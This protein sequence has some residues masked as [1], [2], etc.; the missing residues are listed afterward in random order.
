MDLSELDDR[1]Q[2]AWKHNEQKLQL[3]VRQVKNYL[4]LIQDPRDVARLSIRQVVQRAAFL[5][6]FRYDWRY[7]RRELTDKK[8]TTRGWEYLLLDIMKRLVQSFSTDTK[9]GGAT[10]FF[11]GPTFET[12]KNFIRDNMVTRGSGSQLLRTYL[13]KDTADWRPFLLLLMFLH[14]REVLSAQGFRKTFQ[15]TIKPPPTAASVTAEAIAALEALSS[16]E[17]EEESEEEQPLASKRTAEGVSKKKGVKFTEEQKRSRRETR[18]RR[19]GM[20]PE[21]RKLDMQQQ[22]KE[23]QQQK[24]AATAELPDIEEGQ[25]PSSP[26]YPAQSPR[27]APV[28]IAPIV[29]SSESETEEELPQPIE[30]SEEEEEEEIVQIE[31]SEEEEEEESE[32]ESEEE[33]S[34]LPPEY[35]PGSAVNATTWESRS[36]RN[37]LTDVSNGQRQINVFSV[38]PRRAGHYITKIATDQLFSQQLWEDFAVDFPDRDTT[39]ARAVVIPVYGNEERDL[40]K[41]TEDDLENVVTLFPAS[42]R[43]LYVWLKLKTEEETAEEEKQKEKQRQEQEEE[44][45]QKR[46]RKKEREKR[47]REKELAREKKRQEKEERRVEEAKARQEEEERTRA[48]TAR[49]ERE[50]RAL[51]EAAQFE[52]EQL[53]LA[54]EREEAAQRE[55]IAREEYARRA[56][57][58]RAAA[59]QA[60]RE[61]ESR[62]IRSPPKRRR[63]IGEGVKEEQSQLGGWEEE[64]E[65]E[66]GSEEEIVQ[67]R[68]PRSPPVRPLLEGSSRGTKK[69]KGR[70]F[71]ES[72]RRQA[73]QPPL[74]QQPVPQPVP[75]QTAPARPVLPLL[76]TDMT[77]LFKNIRLL[78]EIRSTRASVRSVIRFLKPTAVLPTT[79]TTGL[80]DDPPP[81]IS[82]VAIEAILDYAKLLFTVP[83]SEALYG[84][85]EGYKELLEELKLLETVFQR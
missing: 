53:L 67:R 31:E 19:K 51:E 71:G 40:F 27:P 4:E 7:T 6:F 43:V 76:Y 83:E 57:E 33:E 66:Q 59:E 82:N 2:A 3:G 37:Q 22:R 84:N 23:R 61:L 46:E 14:K 69:Q 63:D 15:N 72:I 8:I 49:L 60:L 75:R 81:A 5:D 52:R 35:I 17:E 41:G 25:Y 80:V 62:A 70:S 13:A 47:K 77:A 42:K 48:E 44:E 78:A 30:I 36:G 11:I 18:E 54:Q 12:V 21:Q 74:P 24:K 16:S 10:A 1:L 50:R 29:I 38:D 65:E 9:F 55:L 68:R 32:E 20:T 34:F 85:L 79:N 58:T 73:D 56:E 64:E 39:G 26:D 45:R 28:V